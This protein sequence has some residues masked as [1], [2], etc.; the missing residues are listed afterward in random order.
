[1][2]RGHR[3]SRL[4]FSIN[5]YQFLVIQRVGITVNAVLQSNLKKMKAKNH[6]TLHLGKSI[7]RSPR[8]YRFL[9]IP[10]VFAFLV[11]SPQARAVCQE[12][13]DSTNTFIGD[14]VLLSNKGINNTA[15]GSQALHNNT[16]GGENT[17]TGAYA[18]YSNEGLN[19]GHA[20]TA[21]GAYALY[22]NSGTSHN[23]GS[24][25][26]ANGAYALY[27]NTDGQSNT[28]NGYTA[29]YHNTTGDYNTA[30]GDRA[31]FSNTTANYNTAIGYSALSNNTTGFQN[32]A[33]GAG[34][35]GRNTTGNRN[36]AEGYA[37]LNMNRTGNF[38][39]AVGFQALWQNGVGSN[40][41]ALGFN[42]GSNLTQGNG[43]VCIGYNVVGVAGESNTTRIGNIFA[44][45]ASGRA[46]YVNSD[47]KIGT[48]V[49]SRRFKE[50]IKPMNEASEA[51]LALKPITFH[52][53]KEIEPNGGIMFGLIAE[54]VEKVDPDLVTRN[55][56]GD[57][58]TVRYDA[59]NAMLLNEFLKEH[60]KVED[61]E[62]TIRQLR[63]TV[64]QQQKDFQATVVQL[65]ARLDEQASQIQKVSAQ[66]AVNRQT[67]QIISS[68][69]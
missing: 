56:K 2:E 67:S 36:V 68:N 12:G 35:L 11:L 6:T 7:S 40:N 53:K 47:N 29:L 34:A 25:N 28:S 3:P 43:N 10:L 20:N 61:Q 15:I 55:D 23:F 24:E 1:M 9:L 19:G 58:E 30:Y 51:I 64:A 63:S 65:T 52:Y 50:E 21:T 4:I 69:Q 38:N 33:N 18:L 48:L 13:C 22:S 5:V 62:A 26:T 44:S 32:I 66:L 17:A 16:S 8:R 49:S 60:R 27:S 39:T 57:V 37:A 54:D 14:D 42:A 31:L 45:A 41:V 59:V 46:V